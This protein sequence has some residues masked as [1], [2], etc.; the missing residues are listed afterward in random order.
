MTFT[1]CFTNVDQVVITVSNNT[2]CCTAVE[3]E[4]FSSS[5]E[6]RR[7]VAYFPSLAI[8]CALLPAERTSCP[9]FP[10]YKLN[11]VYLSTNWIFCKWQ[12]VSNS[13]LCFSTVHNRH[14][15]C[16]SFWS[17]DI[18]FLTICVADQ[19]DVCCSVWIVLD[20]DYSCRNTI[21]SFS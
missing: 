3:T 5:P 9:P 10:G 8:S 19:S 7:S 1:S 2:D 11:V 18:C 12:A 17:K 20:T 4:P 6:G 16:Q 15:V 13:D 21:F 14:A